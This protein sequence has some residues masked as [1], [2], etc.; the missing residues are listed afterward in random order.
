MFNS[1]DLYST[2]GGV[3][4]FD[5]W[6]PFV[7][8]HDTSSFYNWEQDNL[9]LYDLEER[10][11]Y[12]WE[13]FGY[14]LS[15][16]PG[17]ALVVSATIP[18]TLA[19]S[20]NIFTSVSA[21]IASLPEIIRMPTLIEVAVAGNLGDLNLNN[22]KCEDDG[23]LEII[24]RAGAP[25]ASNSDRTFIHTA[26]SGRAPWN[27]P[28]QLSATQVFGTLS[29]M[30]A[31]SVSAC[32]SAVF[33]G[34]V[35]ADT[36][37]IILAGRRAQVAGTIGY[38]DPYYAYA[39]ISNDTTNWR[40]GEDGLGG[41]ATPTM[42]SA[43]AITQGDAIPIGAVI[44]DT[45]I[46][47]RDVSCI[48]E[49]DD[50]MVSGHQYY[51]SQ[52]VNGLLTGNWFDSVAA[53]NCD[54]PI[55]IRNFIV[56]GANTTTTGFGVYNCNN[57]TLENCGAM[58]CTTIGFDI[59]NSNAN[60]RRQAFATRNYDATNR[61]SI[62]TYGFKITDSDVNFVTD[63]YT[64]G[65]NAK[66]ASHFHDYG[67]YLD[68]S[69]LRGG[70]ILTSPAMRGLKTFSTEIGLN[71][72]NLYLVNS[73]Y[74]MDG[75]TSVYG[76][77][78]NI[79]SYDSSIRVEQLRNK[80]AQNIGL[81]MSNSS[82]KYNKNLNSSAVGQFS[83]INV[84]TGA[85]GANYPILFVKNGQ[86]IVLKGGSTYGPTLNNS[87][88]SSIDITTL[89]NMEMYVEHQGTIS[90]NESNRLSKP[91]IVVDNST[92]QF[93]CSKILCSESKSDLAF[94]YSSPAAILS[95]NNASVTVMGLG[96]VSAG[97]NTVSYATGNQSRYSVG[98]LADKGS[99][100]HF[101]GPNVICNFGICAAA[102]NGSKI[103]VGVPLTEYGTP[104]FTTS[105]W[106][107]GQHPAIPVMEVHSG[108]ACF[109][110]DNNSNLVFEDVG[111]S[112]RYWNRFGN[113]TLSA[114]SDYSLFG[115]TEATYKANLVASGGLQF[116]PN[117]FLP[118]GT[119]W[120]NTIDAAAKGNF[121]KAYDYTTFTAG[122]Y[123]NTL[124]QDTTTSSLR[125]LY[126]AN[127]DTLDDPEEMQQIS[128]GGMCVRATGGS[129]VK[130]RN[131]HFPTGWANT[132]GSFYDASS[133]P[134]GCDNLMIWNIADTSRLHASYI[135]VSGAYPTDAGYRG[136]RSFYTSGGVVGK[137]FSSDASTVSYTLPPGTPH[138]SRLAVLDH[139]GSGTL[140]SG[141]TPG[142]V[143]KTYPTTPSALSATHGFMSAL[144][145]VRV[146]AW[147]A[148]P[149]ATYGESTAENQ[150]AFRLYFSVLPAAKMLSYVSGNPQPTKQ[151]ANR[152]DTKPYQHLSQGYL[153]SGDCSGPKEFSG[154]YPQLL[155]QQL[156][157]QS[158]IIYTSGY[159]YPSALMPKERA[160]VWLDE[161][162]A[163]LFA[164]AKHCNTNYSNRIKLV[165]IYR[166]KIDNDGEAQT[167][168]ESF[169]GQTGLG[170]GFR[171][172]NIFD[173]DRE[174]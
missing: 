128:Q 113:F 141:S 19:T 118:L 53:Q 145:G 3:T 139:F 133:S 135:A 159:Y 171:S 115:A 1:S 47:I 122:G 166:A 102:L 90:E 40:N 59:K 68:N 147:S 106:G 95:T 83:Q 34:S 163:N 82:F 51:N 67:I 105:G 93:T 14:P 7:T 24:N 88:L 103:S 2:S 52:I 48:S 27:F 125:V 134:A 42:L 78:N 160:D 127:Y 57:I 31:I 116:Y 137:G 110:A 65:V 5:Y 162:A 18:N 81:L 112:L 38:Y 123:T 9:P 158:G 156:W 26:N 13:K 154:L 76:S 62:K 168:T 75:I 119:A 97:N 50:S 39:G 114:N 170:L 29:S 72:T 73:K 111:S 77:Y 16:I 55:Y 157:D 33:Y 121:R 41:P 117:G 10:T 152:E 79:E 143:N 25:L 92:A 148:P 142:R 66:L 28:G 64:S 172:A 23:I 150:G 151:G 63:T 109:V 149:L 84:V 155:N 20:A 153:L 70:D 17:M 87:T 94:V 174:I 4:I 54:G 6:N 89:Y 144:Q 104:D 56:D 126:N 169:P 15:S 61:G 46:G 107:R 132:D 32:T 22:I 120:T 100:I 146:P 45:T 130:V 101:T 108:R 49:I 11:E 69:V 167:P 91:A 86:H 131:V 129:N 21:A 138:T 164:N 71:Q 37:K 99:S 12:L 36:R 124:A 85:S 58:R 98:Y 96:N 165:N 8:K 60:L 30:S 136:P 140:V 161:S 74:E 43:N 80:F 44:T 173:I 35:D